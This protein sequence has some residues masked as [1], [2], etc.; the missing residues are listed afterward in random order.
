MNRFLRFV[1]TRRDFGRNDSG[2]SSRIRQNLRFE[3]GILQRWALWGTHNYC[4]AA[5]IILITNRRTNPPATIVA[6]IAS[7]LR[8]S[9]TMPKMP[10][11]K[12]RGI[13]Q[14]MSNPPRA[15]RG[16]PHPGRRQVRITNVA[17]GMTI[18]ID[19][20]LPN[21]ILNLSKNAGKNS[22]YSL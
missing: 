13:E 20:I 18:K 4:A 14:I 16:L 17:M 11:I 19:A 22:V 7:T 5:M 9:R 21:R 12:A 2:A 6:R 1:P 15:A 8:L 3:I 10:N